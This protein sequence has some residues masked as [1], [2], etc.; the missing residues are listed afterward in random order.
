[1]LYKYLQSNLFQKNRVL[2]PKP[3]DLLVNEANKGFHSRSALW[4]RRPAPT[5]KREM[6]IRNLGSLGVDGLPS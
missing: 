4:F 5:H 3:L 1:M 6:T 2:F